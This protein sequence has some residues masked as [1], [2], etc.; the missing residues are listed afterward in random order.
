MIDS[1]LEATLLLFI[2]IDPIMLIP[3]FINLTRGY[4]KADQ[5]LIAFKAATTTL[6]LLSVFWLFGVTMLDSMGIRMS[7][8]KII[9]GL[10]LIAI[11][12]SMVFDKRSSRKNNTAEVALDD[13]TITSVAVFPLAIPL[14]AGPAALATALL[15][16]GNKGNDI[17]GYMT[18]YGPI[19]INC[20]LALIALMFAVKAGKYIGPTIITVTEKIFGLL[21]G[22][23]AIEFIIEGIETSFNL[24]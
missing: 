4:S 23:L 17:N 8:F 18:S 1:F 12:A 7:S 21:L 11:A 3:I 22:A 16:G 9:G 2:A 15:L 20:L 14:M 13:E 5:R 6:I 19:L 10:F 24:A